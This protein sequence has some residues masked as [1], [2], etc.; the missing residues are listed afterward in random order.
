MDVLL[1]MI[2]YCEHNHL[3]C[4]QIHPP[5]VNAENVC[6]ATLLLGAHEKLCQCMAASYCLVLLQFWVWPI[7]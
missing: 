2:M 4:Y 1:H 5:I 3:P 6:T 7:V